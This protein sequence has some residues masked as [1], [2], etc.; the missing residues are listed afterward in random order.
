MDGIQTK[1]QFQHSVWRIAL[2]ITAF[3]AFILVCVFNGLSSN[4]SNG[5]DLNEDE[6]LKNMTVVQVYSFKESDA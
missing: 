5:R 1:P 6:W 2:I 4:R 3:V